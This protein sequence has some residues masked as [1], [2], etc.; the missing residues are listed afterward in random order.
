MSCIGRANIYK[1]EKSF[2]FRMK[3][4]TAVAVLRQV[5][6]TGLDQFQDLQTICSKLV[7]T[8]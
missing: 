2:P 1:K 5:N 4:L 8:S 6:K 7:K 3:I